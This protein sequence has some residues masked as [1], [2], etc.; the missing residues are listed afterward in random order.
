MLPLPS[1]RLKRSIMKAPSILRFAQSTSLRE[2]GFGEAD[3]GENIKY[4]E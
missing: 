1:L 3:L 2:G 4:V